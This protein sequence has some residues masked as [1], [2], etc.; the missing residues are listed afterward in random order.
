MVK[1]VL[2]FLFL[3]LIP[4]WVAA[5]ILVSV[6][7][8]WFQPL[9]SF[10]SSALFSVTAQD[11]QTVVKYRVSPTRAPQTLTVAWPSGDPRSLRAYQ[12]A[13]AAQDFIDDQFLSRNHISN[14]L[15]WLDIP[16]TPVLAT[17]NTGIWQPAEDNY[18]QLIYRSADATYLD[19]ILDRGFKSARVG[20]TGVKSGFFQSPVDPFG[21][22]FLFTDRAPMPVEAN[23]GDLFDL[24]VSRYNALTE[25]FLKEIWAIN[26][27]QWSVVTWVTLLTASLMTMLPWLFF[28]RLKSLLP[29]V[30]SLLVAS[31]VAP[32]LFQLQWNWFYPFV[33][34]VLSPLFAWLWFADKAN[35]RKQIAGV[36]EKRRDVTKLW[37]GHLLDEGKPEAAYRYL[38]RRSRPN[39]TLHRNVAIGCTRF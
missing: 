35:M 18:K 32:V 27:Q 20:F 23:E 19:Q 9:H 8:A 11:V 21:G 13:F 38:K 28:G 14:V 6:T 31:V 2:R 29:A 15:H 22:I 37:V 24:Q 34:P 5:L 16:E 12:S 7:F 30:V 39:K 25:Q 1:P 36:E 4:G 17:A 33:L 3:K 10:V 26:N